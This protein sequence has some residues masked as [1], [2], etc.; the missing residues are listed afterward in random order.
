MIDMSPGLLKHVL[1]VA[2]VDG[3][4]QCLERVDRQSDRHLAAGTQH[5]DRTNQDNNTGSDH[6]DPP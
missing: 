6:R 2:A 1:T 5:Q 3:L 4:R